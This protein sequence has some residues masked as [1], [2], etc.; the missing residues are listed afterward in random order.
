[1][2]D[3]SR[4]LD[5]IAELIAEK[6]NKAVEEVVNALIE[7]TQGKTGEEALEVLAN[8]NLKY[9][10]ESKLAGV[11]G[12]YEQGI[13]TMLENMYSTTTLS[14]LT[15][16]T[17][18][19]N[20][21]RMLASEFVDKISGNILQKSITGISSKQTVNEILESIK[22]VTPDIETQVVTAYGQYSSAVSNMLSEQLPDDTKYIYIGAYD[23]KTRDR[24]V[25][26]IGFS[27]A[28]REDIISRFGD[29]NNE[30]WNCRHR[31]E[32]RS[33]SPVDQGFNKEKFTDA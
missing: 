23:S 10:M 20:S 27:P 24:C 31:W 11:F 15:L 7:L 33:S 3:I 17:L 1:M 32:Q 2:A 5:R 6:S 26:K 22:D 4:E 25:E 8:I 9:A 28:T 16:R 14:E 19:N 13:V 18:L 12:L 29:F 21:S 30:I